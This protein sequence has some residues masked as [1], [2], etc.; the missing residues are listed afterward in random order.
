MAT[1][2]PVDPDLSLSTERA[3]KPPKVKKTN[4]YDFPSPAGAK[5]VMLSARKKAK[6]ETSE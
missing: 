4:M 3:F 1:E 6:D 2:P 5:L